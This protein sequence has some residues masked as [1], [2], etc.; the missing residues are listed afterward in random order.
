MNDPDMRGFHVFGREDCPSCNKA[1]ALLNV[2]G[3]EKETTFVRLGPDFKELHASNCAEFVPAAH[4][5]VPIIFY[6]KRFLGGYEQLERWL[7]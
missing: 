3:F 2:R 4:V 6:N 5:T 1:L 7:S